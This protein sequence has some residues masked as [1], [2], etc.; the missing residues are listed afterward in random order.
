MKTTTQYIKIQNMEGSIESSHITG[1]SNR[2]VN[3]YAEEKDEESSEVNQ[4]RLA[5]ML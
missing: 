2:E 5:M 4:M 1:K 3:E